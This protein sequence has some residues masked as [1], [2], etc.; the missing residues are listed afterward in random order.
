MIRENVL[1]P[2]NL[3]F[4]GLFLFEQFGQSP[5]RANVPGLKHIQLLVCLHGVGDGHKAEQASGVV[6][7]VL[8]LGAAVHR[9]S[10]TRAR[11]SDSSRPW[12]SLL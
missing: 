12:A 9:A 4:N 8:V 7:A 11:F 6:S 1:V 2:L 10:Q 3:G 5:F